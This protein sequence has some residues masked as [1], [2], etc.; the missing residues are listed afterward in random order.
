LLEHKDFSKTNG[1]LEL[2]FRPLLALALMVLYPK[3]YAPSEEQVEDVTAHKHGH[4]AQFILQ[5]LVT[6]I[7]EVPGYSEKELEDA[8]LPKLENG[9]FQ[10]FRLPGKEIYLGDRLE[11]ILMQFIE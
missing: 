2:Y 9:L 5:K 3:R 10:D 8:F 1:L 6:S 4:L 11:K 7:L